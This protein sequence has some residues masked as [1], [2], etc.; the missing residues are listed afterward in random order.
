M[1]QRSGALEMV[2]RTDPGRVRAHNEDAV[3]A[4]AAQG[5]AILADGM[6]GYNGGEVASGMATTLLASS[7]HEV[8]TRCTS[9][10]VG[11]CGRP[12]IHD[13][14]RALIATANLSIFN[15]AQ[16]QPQYVGMGTTLVLTWLSDNWLHVA[17]VGDS[18]LYRLR[19][20]Q[21]QQLT[22]DHSLLQDQIDSGMIDPADARTSEIRNLVTRALGV[23]AMVDVEFGDHEVSKGDLYLLCSDGLNDM[24]TD[25]QIA[26]ILNSAP[27]QIDVLADDLI[28]IAN[29]LGG[30]DNVSVILIKVR[31]DFAAPRY[32]WQRLLGWL[33]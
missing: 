18:R 16:L 1:S 32:W 31:G 3:F 10:A 27:D 2:V 6:G 33:K 29:G 26:H 17:H 19:D 22:R 25:E 7:F 13:Q 5:L 8:L 30:R 15:T 11:F 24:L 4:D 21:L 23:E 14:I 9:K 12:F 28:E 20:G